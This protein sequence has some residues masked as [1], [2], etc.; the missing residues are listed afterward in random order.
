MR[1]G[2]NERRKS[3][4]GFQTAASVRAAAVVWLM[5]D[6]EFLKRHQARMADT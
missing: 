1:M 3:A 5:T 6:D 2:A 4:V